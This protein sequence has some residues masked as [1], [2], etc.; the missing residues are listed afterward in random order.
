MM[1]QRIFNTL[2]KCLWYNV[3]WK[4]SKI[5]NNTHYKLKHAKKAQKRLENFTCI[6]R[7]ITYGAK[8]TKRSSIKIKEVF[9]DPTRF[10]GRDR[11]QLQA[12]P[13]LF[14]FQDQTPLWV[15]LWVIVSDAFLLPST[16]PH[17]LPKN[18]IKRILKIRWASP[19]IGTLVNYRVFSSPRP[20]G[21]S[22]ET[23]EKKWIIMI[24][25]QTTVKALPSERDSRPVPSCTA[26]MPWV[27]GSQ[28][29]WDW[30]VKWERTRALSW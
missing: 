17:P 12:V 5:H 2:R 3:K 27:S 10:R 20:R 28:L 23:K 14:A 13:L 8:T 4:N 26:D 11:R 7:V 24:I 29:G 6:L 18:I 9:Q 25:T 16:F 22:L 15:P 30:L 19:R 21:W 1:L